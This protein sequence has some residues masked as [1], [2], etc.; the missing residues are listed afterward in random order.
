MY[1]KSEAAQIRKD[2]WITLDVYSRKFL[3]PNRK[4]VAYNTG[5]K[6]FVL[7]FDLDKKIG[8]VM[9]SIEQKSEN[10]RFDIFVKL[11]EFELIYQD[12]LGEGWIWDEQLM[13]SN[14]KEVCAIYKQI[15]EVNIYNKDTWSDVF[16]FFGTEMIK[17][18]E[19]FEEVK[20]LIKDYIKSNY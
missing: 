3:G 19:A 14:G 8:R 9:L 10:K 16:E 7:K 17:L 18:E 20:S 5:I 12:A 2:F 1:S 13:L 11:K 6:D 15:E 4:W